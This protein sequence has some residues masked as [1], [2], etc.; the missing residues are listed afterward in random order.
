M[1]CH[2]AIARAIGNGGSD[3]LF[4]VAGDGNLFVAA[5]FA[6]L[7]G[8]RYVSAVHESGAV[9]MASGYAQLADCIGLATVT[10]GPGLSNAVTALIDA[11]RAGRPL[12]VIAGDLGERRS[13]AQHLDQELVVGATGAGFLRVRSGDAGAE[14]ALQAL[15]LSVRERRPYVL[16]VPVEHLWEEH[17]DEVA[18]RPV[19]SSAPGPAAAADAEIDAALGIAVSAARPIVLAGVGCASDAGRDA[20]LSL[21]ET[22]G[23]PVCTTVKAKGLFDGHPADLGIFGTLADQDALAT[24]DASDCL[25]V[26]GASLSTYTTD[27]GGLIRGKSVVHCDIDSDHIGRFCDV[28]TGVVGDAASTAA[29]M[30]ELLMAEQVDRPRWYQPIAREAAVGSVGGTP[31]GIT[32]RRVLDII[33]ATLPADRVLVT[34][35]G[36]FFPDAISSISVTDPRHYVHGV[37][38]GSVGLGTGLA[39]GAATAAPG[40]TVLLVIGDGG[41]MMSGLAELSTAARTGAK[42]VVVVSNDGAYGSEYVQLRDRGWD[43]ELTTFQWPDFADVARTFDIDAVTI[44]DADD[45]PEM[46]ALL[47]KQS[48][49]LLVDVRLDPELVPRQVRH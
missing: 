9:A 28:T 45:L 37:N 8:R 39:I 36:R 44:R 32:L 5:S 2:E 31:S 43:P 46:I 48:R 12:L 22:L 16:S 26:F 49:P 11:V 13:H 6:A 25:L 1:Y 20:L 18:V 27:A 29:T 15:D 30:R 19:S 14:C 38:F 10:H 24:F 7:H 47:R 33:N 34:D 17:P 35:V 41:L 40:R 3:T 21:A 42:L 4:G 23:A